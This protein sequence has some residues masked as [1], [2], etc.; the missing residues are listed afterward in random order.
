[1]LLWVYNQNMSD[2]SLVEWTALEYEPKNRSNDWLWSVGLGALFLV[3]IF[4]Y[5]GNFLFSIIIVLVAIVIILYARRPPM[6][7]NFALTTKGLRAEKELYPFNTLKDFAISKD[8]KKLVIESSRVFF[9]RIIVPLEN[10]PVAQIREELRR[11]VKEVEYEEHF[12]DALAD[13][14]GF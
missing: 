4:L 8:S 6:E 11:R 13:R 14:L 3:V 9:P 5:F 2:F 10:A 7:I 12:L 1:M